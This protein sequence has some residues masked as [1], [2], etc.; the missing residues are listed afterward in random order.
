M[1]VDALHGLALFRKALLHSR[2]SQL[3]TADVL[4]RQILCCGGRP[5]RCG[6]FGSILALYPLDASTPPHPQL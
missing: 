5:V 6:M 3:S 2:V 1:S 4:D